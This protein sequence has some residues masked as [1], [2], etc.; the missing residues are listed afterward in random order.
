MRL[1]FSM[2]IRKKRSRNCPK[3]KKFQWFVHFVVKNARRTIGRGYLGAKCAGC[4]L[5]G[6]FI[7][8]EELSDDFMF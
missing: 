4:G 1:V 2:E 7:P 6:G 5:E 8:K 3:R